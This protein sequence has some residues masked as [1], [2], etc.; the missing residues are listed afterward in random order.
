M[1]YTMER[2]QKSKKTLED[3]CDTFEVKRDG[4]LSGEHD[5]QPVEPSFIALKALPLFPRD[6]KG[7]Y[8]RAEFKKG[9]KL[10]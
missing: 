6:L 10:H 7:I 5:R 1:E 9:L 2:P 8:L 3:F 4:T